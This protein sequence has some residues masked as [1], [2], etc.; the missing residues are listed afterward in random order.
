M[1]AKNG[2]SPR[3]L[4]TILDIAHI[5]IG[6]LVIIMAFFAFLSPERYMVLFP[7]IFLLASALNLI[8]GCFLLKMYPRIKKK[9][10]SGIAYV[11]VG[12]LIAVLCILS[13]VS[14]WGNAS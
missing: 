9:K 10:A 8:T 5:V 1:A 7:L 13:A 2:Y 4:G 11:I 14:I 6:I 3:K 12:S